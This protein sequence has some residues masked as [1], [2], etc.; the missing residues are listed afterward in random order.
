MI[1]TK[2]YTT[3]EEIKKAAFEVL[4]DD[5]HAMVE[6]IVQEDN[7][8][9]KTSNIHVYLKNKEDQDDPKLQEE[10]KEVT[11]RVLDNRQKASSQPQHPSMVG[12]YARISEPTGDYSVVNRIGQNDF[13]DLAPGPLRA[14]KGFYDSIDKNMAIS[15]MYASAV[16]G[17]PRQ[18]KAIKLLT[19]K[20]EDFRLN[21]KT[22]W[23]KWC[24]LPSYHWA[25]C[26]GHWYLVAHV[27]KCEEQHGA[28][29]EQYTCYLYATFLYLDTLAGMLTWRLTKGVYRFDKHLW[30]A[31]V[32]TSLDGQIPSNALFSLPEWC[33]YVE[34]PEEYRQDSD[35]TDFLRQAPGRTAFHGFFAYLDYPNAVRTSGDKKFAFD[36]D[37]RRHMEELQRRNLVPESTD[38]KQ[39]QALWSE[40]K[41]RICYREDAS[42]ELVILINTETYRSYTHYSAETEDKDHIFPLMVRMSIS[43]G[44]WSIREGMTNALSYILDGK[45]ATNKIYYNSLQ[46]DKYFGIAS[47]C[48]SALMYL[49]S[50]N[51][52]IV[53]AGTN[54]DFKYYNKY[55]PVKPISSG[56]PNAVKEWD[57][58]QRQGAVI[59]RGQEIIDEARRREEQEM[60]TVYHDLYDDCPDGIDVGKVRSRH[61]SLAKLRPHW[62]AGHFHT[63][64]VGSKKLQQQEAVVKWVAPVLVNA[65]IGNVDKLPEVCRPV[66]LDQQRKPK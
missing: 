6:R 63:F 48:V 47:K 55:L 29:S 25:K 17:K 31:V 54:K 58:G 53:K 21:Y 30:K 23:P 64:W 3:P 65:T 32:S 36:K 8:D 66:V 61:C 28:D 50:A 14:L 38:P 45:K 18:V 39:D 52:D 62:R 60:R 37:S 44:D 2:T 9:T 20:V 1:T 26:M 13:Y 11:S 35:Y 7:Y 33:V 27:K 19:K 46:S 5:P 49:S 24:Y 56:A 51:A 34:I 4:C 12:T 16:P 22:L 40:I 15:S 10:I 42:A 57:V 59:R 41:S 43:I